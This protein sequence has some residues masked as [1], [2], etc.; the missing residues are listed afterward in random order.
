VDIV[1]SAQDYD[2]MGTFDIVISAETLEHDSDP[3]GQIESAGR[4][5]KTGGKLII[6]AAAEPRK[7]HRCDGFDGG[8]N[9]E[10]YQNIKPA[11]LL[12]WLQDWVIFEIEHNRQHGDVYALAVKK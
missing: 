3:R 10:Y 12:G 2:G 4:A 8:L 9:G 7:P 5:L 1:S 11:D 6:T